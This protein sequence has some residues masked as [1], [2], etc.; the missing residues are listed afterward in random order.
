MIIAVTGGAGYIG[1]FL[2]QELLAKNH[3]VIS[4]DNET[5][6]NYRYLRILN[7][8]NLTIIN[9][10]VRDS[11]HLQKIFQNVDAIAHLAALPGLIQCMESPEEAVSINIFGTQNV[12]ETAI[13]TNVQKVVFCSTA[14][15]Y[16][17]PNKIPVKETQSLHP[18]NLYGVTKLTGEK[19]LEYYYK[20]SKINTVS[21]RFGNVYGVGMYTKWNTVVPKF[22]E[23]GLSGKPLSI[24]GDGNSTRDFVHV[25]DICQAIILSLTNPKVKCDVFNV[26]NECTTINGIAN[27]VSEAIESITGIKV[28][29]QWLPPRVGETKEFAYNLSKIKQKLGYKPEWDLKDGIAQLIKY[30]INLEKW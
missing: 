13:K 1:S 27:L 16:G 3:K 7:N 20:N 23:L 11:K 12:L 5:T 25:E 8:S 4:I 30:K 17:K 10:D 26:G 19:I 21:L 15:V 2:I 14:A 9:G 28:E 6:G 29:K 22:V 24:F 18:M